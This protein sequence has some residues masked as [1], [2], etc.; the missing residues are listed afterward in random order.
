MRA[1]QVFAAA[2]LTV[3]AG[4]RVDGTGTAQTTTSA[5]APPAA[6]SEV[7]ATELVVGDCLGQVALGARERALVQSVQVVSCEQEH[8][9]EVF[10]TFV[11]DAAGFETDPPGAY[12]GQERIV[13]AADEGCG[14]EL[15]DLAGAEA[16]GL[17]ALWPS[18]ESWQAGDR[19]VA[20]AA[21]P[22]DGSKFE[23]RRLLAG[24]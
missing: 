1:R 4:C 16:F 3:V 22:I 20:C 6:S 15:E 14:E 9:L 10:A 18:V 23:A 13:R 2:A 11:L 24:A 12:P 7:A 17:I 5:V 8:E 19:T 21:F